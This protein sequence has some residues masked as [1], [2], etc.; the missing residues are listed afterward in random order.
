MMIPDT[1]PAYLAKALRERTEEEGDCLLWTGVYASGTPIVYVPLAEHG[2]QK[3]YITVRKAMLQAHGTKM[4][5]GLYAIVSCGNPQCVA[6][7]HVRPATAS[8]LGR[9]NAAS[10]NLQDPVRR[11][12]IAR[13]RQE[14]GKLTCGVVDAIRASDEP[15]RLLAKRY[16]VSKS[17]ISQ[18]KRHIRWV[19]RPGAAD[20]GSVFWRLA[21]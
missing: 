4:R 3:R 12:K 13:T 18:I 7:A 5:Q 19:N 15:Q 2:G 8:Q 11:A 20:W 1:W 9:R 21:A 14:Q 10:G 16:G 6:P 17:T